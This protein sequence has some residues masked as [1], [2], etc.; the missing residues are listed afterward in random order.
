MDFIAEHKKHVALAKAGGFPA[1]GFDEWKR[2]V[3]NIIALEEKMRVE[4]AADIAAIEP[5]KP[6]LV[7]SK[8]DKPV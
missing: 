4:R 7:V 1:M 8:G 2:E 6:K 3:I 5:W